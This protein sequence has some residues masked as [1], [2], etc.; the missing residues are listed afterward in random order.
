[1]DRPNT[2]KP[3]VD[4]GGT[5]MILRTLKQLEAVGVKRVVIVVGY[6]SREIERALTG[7]PDLGLEPEF[8][9]HEDWSRGLASSVLAARDR[10]DEPFL[11]AMG[12]HVFDDELVRTMVATELGRDALAV[13]VDSRTDEI[14]DLDSAVKV[15]VAGDRVEA[16][17]R[18]LESYT[19]VDASLFVA[20]P[21]FLDALADAVGDQIDQP[22]LVVGVNALARGGRVRAIPTGPR[23]W[24]DVDTPSS[25]IAAEIAFRE[26]QR[27]R[28]IKPPKRTRPAGP[29]ERSYRFATGAP[30]ETKILLQQGFV[31]EPS[32]LDLIPPESAS[33]PLFVFT[34]TRVNE[35]YGYEFV[36]GLRDQ[37]YQV[38]R[39]VVSQ[40]EESKTLASYARLV[41]QVLGK[42]I[43]ERS[44]LIS[45]G[46]GAICNVCGF[47]AS[48]LYRG[49]GLIHVPTTL[50]AQCDAA[51]S[52]KQGVNGHKGKNL[53]GSYYAPLA[54]AIDIDVLATLDDW[55]IP[56]GLSEVI[57][58]ALGQDA[59]YLEDLLEYTG[60]VNDPE[61]LAYVVRRN[62]E[63]KCELLANDPKELR[64]AMVLQYGHTVGHP[65]EYLSGYAWSHGQAVAAGMMVA[66]HVSRILGGGDDGLVDLHR[67]LISKFGLP[68]A[69][70]ESIDTD[71]V[72]ATMRYNKRY[73]VEGTRMALLDRP[74]GLWSV[75]NEYAIPVSDRVLVEALRASR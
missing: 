75:E 60:D 20:T 68:A 46:G 48:T 54:I 74:G 51:I 8:I 1:M 7:H 27:A 23:T 39:V 21:A 41:E 30:T 65:I 13:L 40:G 63:L 37:G 61:F 2:P 62:I 32:C 43:D 64:E 35:L 25:V 59:A 57:K 70:P 28:Q 58:H 11:L 4:I 18:G 50:M 42:G 69:I 53:V 36:E 9:H 24:F 6:S 3:L 49:V 17:G 56:D 19:A 34:D 22:E 66:A 14:L 72:L 5:P 47:I 31:G 52:H 44:I 33:S 55:M 45:L 38:H 67:H 10:L 26:R 12:D 15:A 16:T 71:A 73:L 29:A